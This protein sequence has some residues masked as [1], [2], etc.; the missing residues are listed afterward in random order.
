M[1]EFARSGK[2]AEPTILGGVDPHA[3]QQ[4]QEKGGKA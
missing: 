3:S 2:R 1:A 4:Q